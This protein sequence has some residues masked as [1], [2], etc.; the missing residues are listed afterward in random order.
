MLRVECSRLPHLGLFSSD[1][2]QTRLSRGN[3]M[4]TVMLMM[5]IVIM[6]SVLINSMLIVMLVV[7]MTTMAVM[8]RIMRTHQAIVEDQGS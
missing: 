7:V 1:D 5:A 3:M 8:L 2:N 4:M 6:V